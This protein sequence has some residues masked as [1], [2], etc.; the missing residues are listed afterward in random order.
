M[1]G[2]SLLAGGSAP[3]I[4]HSVLAA[5]SPA[6][7]SSLVRVLASSGTRVELTEKA[8]KLASGQQHSPAAHRGRHASP[9]S[10]DRR[11]T[12]AKA[13][14]HALRPVYLD[15]LRSVSG[16]FPERIDQ[17]VDFTGTGPVYALGD[18][19]V[20]QAVGDSPG[21]PGGG[22]ITYQLTDGPDKGMMV[23]LAEDVTPT[24][25]PGQHVT[26]GT[27]IANMYD[28]GAGIETGWSQE[29]GLAPESQL[30]EA[31]GISGGGPFPTA[32]GANFDELLQAL[33]VP[34][35]QNA[36]EAPFGTLPA[37]YPTSWPGITTS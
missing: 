3:A 36:G 19:V 13:P 2:G 9:A 21:W 5:A 31:G 8:V 7:A 22:W 12:H 27:V 28:G 4:T 32:V 30:L 25:V 33:G 15:P 1:A 29:N 16:L 17:G 6:A 10:A 11:D 34:A 23:Y 37:G 26:P 14:R 35:A 18:G 20:I 24:V